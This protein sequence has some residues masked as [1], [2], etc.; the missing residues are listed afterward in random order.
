[1]HSK[2]F[3]SLP[4]QKLRLKTRLSGIL[5]LLLLV[6]PIIATY[7]Y[8][9]ITKQ[10]IRK[11]VKHN[12]LNKL[13]KENLILL[14]FTKEETENLDWKHSSEFEFQGQMYDIVKQEIQC[15]NILYWCWNDNKETKINNQIN[16]L[17]TFVLG[18]DQRNK[19]N[20][21][22]LNNYFNSLFFSEIPTY[23]LVVLQRDYKYNILKIAC[24]KL[25]NSPPSPPPEIA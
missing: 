7:S 22:R 9:Y 1:M 5:I 3:L 8:L 14:T 25:S 12:I 18:K 11:E 19:E 15:E 10:K 13:E 20:Q 17:L 23:N 6:V 4:P 16:S 24:H 21:K 2:E